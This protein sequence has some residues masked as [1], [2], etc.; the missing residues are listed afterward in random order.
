MVVSL[1]LD[2]RTEWELETDL[3]H[4]RKAVFEEGADRFPQEDTG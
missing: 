4:E 2:V 1:G 3:R